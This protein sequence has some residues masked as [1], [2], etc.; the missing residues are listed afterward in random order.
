[1]SQGNDLGAEAPLAMSFSISASASKVTGLDCCLSS[2]HKPYFVPLL[3]FSFI[4]NT[5][6]SVG[7][8]SY[9]AILL[10]QYKAPLSRSYSMLTARKL[11]RRSTSS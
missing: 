2:D 4:F 10:K 3:L 8:H 6:Y 5:S 7:I 11:P 1:M 9:C